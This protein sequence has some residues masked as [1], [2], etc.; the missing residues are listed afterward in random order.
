MTHLAER[1]TVLETSKREHA[2]DWLLAGMAA[3]L[4]LIGLYTYTVPESWFMGGLAEAWWLGPWMMAGYLMAVAL[5][6]FARM[7]YRRDGP[8]T[9][10]EISGF[11]FAGISLLAGIGFMLLWIL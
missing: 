7:A 5:W 3:V 4:A 11:I 1:R 2:I 6:D 10:A 9:G 8:F